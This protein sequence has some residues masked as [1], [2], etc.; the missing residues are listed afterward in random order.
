M[1]VCVCLFCIYI[2]TYNQ[3]KNTH[4]NSSPLNVPI[5]KKFV[6]IRSTGFRKNAKLAI[7]I[8]QKMIHNTLFQS[9]L[10]IES[11]HNPVTI[12]FQSSTYKYQLI[13]IYHHISQI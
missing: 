4:F 1:Y 3:P 13:Y 5:Q 7:F 12:S 11:P 9:F 10:V 8:G 6:R 2:Y